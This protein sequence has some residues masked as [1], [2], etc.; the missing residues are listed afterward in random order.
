M[1][2]SSLQPSFEDTKDF[3][4]AKRGLIGSLEPCVIEGANGNAV[5]NNDAYAF[6]QEDCPE[7]ANPKLWRHGQLCFLQGVF[8][9]VDRV[10]QVR[11]LDISNLTII[12]GD[13]GL[14][15]VDPLTSSECARAALALYREKTEDFR[16]V[17]AVLYSHSHTDHFSGAAGV[18]PDNRDDWSKVRIIAPEGFME[19]A[20][21]ENVMCGP[22]MS[23]R[24]KF[25]Y[26]NTIEKG[27]AGQIGCGLGTTVSQGTT[28][29]VPPKELIKKTGEEWDIDGVKF[30][31]QI[32][33]GSEA[34]SEFNF[35]LPDHNA[36][37]ISE[38]ACHTLHNIITLRGAQ[39]RDAKIWSK[40]LDE[41]ITLY[42]QH[43]EVLFAGHHWPTWGRD[44]ILTLVAE[45]RDMYTFLHDQTVRL[46]NLG[47]NGAEIA[48]KMVLPPR[49]QTAWHAQGYYGSVSHDVKGI[50]Q[51]YMTW[52]DG[53]PANLWAH[54]PTDAGKRYV[55]CFGGIEN[56]IK[57]GQD[58]AQAGDLRFAATLLDHAVK[59]EP[60]NQ[61]AANALA[62][63]Y[64]KLAHGAENATWRNF[65]LTGARHLN[66]NLPF[67]DTKQPPLNLNPFGTV[68]Q[69][70]DGLAVR[71]DGFAA[72]DIRDPSIFWVHDTKAGLAWTVRLSNAALTYSKTAV[73]KPDP[74]SSLSVAAGTLELRQ[75]LSGDLG[76]ANEKSTGDISVLVDLLKLCDVN[77]M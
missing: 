64:V 48:E 16:P 46:L 20:I 67:V 27:P 6:L 66:E 33:S 7:T 45:Q 29:L 32:V 74:D 77:T 1:A 49:L 21:S 12:V 38:C 76:L 44:E 63:V 71:L 43:T 13:T 23:R 39:V 61:A 5:W 73:D 9:V 30:V 8:K 35:F 75:I 51:R 18:L 59:A 4:N 65:Y 26:G 37:F 11:G 47:Y 24:A 19:E 42:G 70:L 55:E 2:S 36:L 54:P 25:M 15:L 69:W 58:Y 62:D 50:Y 14:V 60:T 34:P 17:V 22:A 56:V 72:S 57:Q 3:E 28:L 41:T 31:F 68:E 53:N 52:F 10:Y 40:F